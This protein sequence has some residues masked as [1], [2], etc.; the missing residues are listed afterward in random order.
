[1]TFVIIFGPPAVGKMT[2]GLELER[3][4]GLRL[5]HN[6]MTI[7]LVLNFF[8][9]G[10]PRFA[11]LVSELRTR[12]CEEVAASDLPGLIFTYV[13]ALDHPSDREFIDHLTG[14]FRQRGGTVCYVELAASQEER[15]R[16]NKTPLRLANKAGKR[17]LA[18]SRARILE[19]DAK[20]RLNTDGDF[21]YPESHLKI[22]NTELSA[23]D[24]ARRVIAH[25][26]LREMSNRA[27]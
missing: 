6:H 25:F 5:F 14:L 13:W 1:M 17:R 4:T 12:V 8:D 3:L 10:E 16:R 19:A 24:V 22:D 18:H 23:V 15:L 9:F 26:G 11:R 27:A 20:Y 21:F 2:V 7:D